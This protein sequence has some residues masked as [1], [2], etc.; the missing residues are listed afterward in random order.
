MIHP[1]KC[2][3]YHFETVLCVI[4]PGSSVGHPTVFLEICLSC[5][6]GPIRVIQIILF[7]KNSSHWWD[8][9]LFFSYRMG[10]VICCDPPLLC[11]VLSG[12]EEGVNLLSFS[13]WNPCHIFTLSFSHFIPHPVYKHKLSSKSSILVLDTYLKAINLPMPLPAPVINTISPDTSFGFPGKINFSREQQTWYQ[14]MKLTWMNSISNAS[15]LNV[16]QIA[17]KWKE[18][19]LRFCNDCLLC[20]KGPWWWLT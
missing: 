18:V 1:R 10:T 20:A 3:P 17:M 7:G 11:F 19:C 8:I 16:L 14:T 5:N 12:D 4:W 9:S 13:L 15:I 2:Q 6:P